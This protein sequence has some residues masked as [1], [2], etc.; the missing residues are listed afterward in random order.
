MNNDFGLIRL[1]DVIALTTLSK[2]TIYRRLATNNFPPK[3]N[4]GSNI[5][6]W[7][8]SD[9]KKYIERGLSWV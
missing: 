2:S 8:V 9:I 4:C 7:R 6:A 5:A 1:E 3:L